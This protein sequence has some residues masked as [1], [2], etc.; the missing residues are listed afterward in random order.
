MEKPIIL[1]FGLIEYLLSLLIIAIKLV[2]SSLILGILCMIVLYYAG[3]RGNII[4]FLATLPSFP[5]VYFWLVRPTLDEVRR[6]WGVPLFRFQ[7][8]L[9]GHKY[10]MS[11]EPPYF[12]WCVWCKKKKEPWP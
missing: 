10:T 4:A 11:P 6:K 9:I 3:M 12:V 2:L 7:C 8:K 5:I 1:E